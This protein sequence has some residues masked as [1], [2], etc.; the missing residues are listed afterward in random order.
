MNI[1]NKVIRYNKEG[2]CVTFEYKGDTPLG[3]K[4]KK[5]RRRTNCPLPPQHLH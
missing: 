3:I 5:R 4:S 2:K 1:F